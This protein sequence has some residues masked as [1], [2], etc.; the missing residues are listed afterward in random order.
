M[1]DVTKKITDENEAEFDAEIE[2]LSENPQFQ[3]I[4][5]KSRRSLKE[6]GDISLSAMR[7]RFDSTKET[8][9]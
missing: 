2:A 4:I 7:K 1:T 3:E 9:N 8:S 6:K 5:A